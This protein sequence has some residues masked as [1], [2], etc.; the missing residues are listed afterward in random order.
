MQQLRREF[1]RANVLL[2]LIMEREQ[3]KKVMFVDTTN[4]P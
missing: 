4:R 3:L 2:E 1:V